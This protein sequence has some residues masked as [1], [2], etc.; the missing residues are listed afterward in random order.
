MSVQRLG[1]KVEVFDCGSGLV[2]SSRE[3]TQ[4]SNLQKGQSKILLQFSFD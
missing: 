2:N 3:T 1:V 4:G